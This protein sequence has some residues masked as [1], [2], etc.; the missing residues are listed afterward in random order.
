[1]SNQRPMIRIAGIVPESVTDGPGVRFTIFTQGCPYGCLDCHNP[2]THDPNGGYEIA[3]DE[4]LDQ[5]KRNPLLDGITFSGGEPFL[6]AA[7]LAKIARA[8]H[9]WNL[10]VMTYTG[11]LY[12][13]ILASDNA[14]WQTLLRETDI[15]V[16]GPFV[17]EQATKTLPFRGSS[18]QKIIALNEKMKI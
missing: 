6:Q 11:N 16:D 15:L 2:H 5:I 17:Q 4:I 9:E 3:I 8:C 13:D 10:T 14:D 18:N 12:E 1:M 7:N